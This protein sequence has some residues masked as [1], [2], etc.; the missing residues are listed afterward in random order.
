MTEKKI[1]LQHINTARNTYKSQ[2]Q[3]MSYLPSS[4]EEWEIEFLE[5][6]STKLLPAEALVAPVYPLLALVLVKAEVEVVVQ[7]PLR[8]WSPGLPG[9]GKVNESLE[10]MRWIE[11][12]SG[13]SATVAWQHR[14][15][16]WTHIAASSGLH[17]ARVGSTRSSAFPPWYS[18]HVCTEER[19]KIVRIKWN[20]WEHIFFYSFP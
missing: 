8:P 16:S 10:N 20:G 11:F 5:Y 7:R 18:F 2:M 19:W 14:S 12:M 15:P 13:R 6:S 3:V 17:L 9:L 4:I 1:T